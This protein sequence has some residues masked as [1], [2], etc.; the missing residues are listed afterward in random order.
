MS[1]SSRTSSIRRGPDAELP[2]WGG[3]EPAGEGF[4]DKASEQAKAARRGKG[5]P[6]APRP[7]RRRG[8]MLL[9]IGAG[10]LVLVVALVALA[11]AI[12]SRFV[13]GIVRDQAAGRITGEVRVSS[14]SLSWLGSQSLANIELIDAGKTIADVSIELDHG[15]LGL[16]AGSRQ[17]GTATLAGKIDLVRFADGT[18]NLERALAP[19]KGSASPAPSGKTEPPRVPD[20]AAVRVV[21]DSLAVSF[22]DESVAGGPLEASL[23]KIDAEA[24]IAAGD[25]VTLKFRSEATSRIGAGAVQSGTI[26]IDARVDKWQGSD[27]SLTPERINVKADLSIKDLPTALIDAL[28]GRGGT[29]AAGLGERLQLSVAAEGSMKSGQATAKLRT[30]GAGPEAALAADVSARFADDV[31][32]LSSP[33]TLA[34]TG[35]ALR[36][37]APQIDR[38]LAGQDALTLEAIPD[39]RVSVGA[40]QARVPRGGAPLDLRR[41]QLELEASAGEVAGRVRLDDTGPPRAMRLAPLSIKVSGPDLGG[42]VR[43]TASTA[44]R[45]ADETGVLASAGTIDADFTLTGLLDGA[46]VP[47]AGVPGGLNGRARV[48]G[49]ATALAQ[50]LVAA[51]GLDLRRDVGPTLDVDLTAASGGS[52]RSDLP[53]IDVTLVVTAEEINAFGA[54]TVLNDRI[55]TR[56]EGMRATLKR[57]GAIAGRFVDPSSGLAIDPTGRADLALTGVSI[58]LSPGRAPLLDQAAARGEVNIAGWTLRGSGAAG[59]PVGLASPIAIASVK[60]EALLAKGRNPEATLNVTG[61]HAGQRFTI[62]GQAQVAGLFKPTPT[63]REP[64]PLDV[65]GAAPI[66]R[67]AIRGLPTAL[68]QGV[69]ALAPAG[70]ATSGSSYRVGEA[71]DLAS[72][73]RDAVGPTLDVVASGEQ[74]GERVV[75]DARIESKGLVT[76]VKGTAD[77]KAITLEPVRAR[78]TLDPV[79]AGRLI[80]TFTDPSA[81]RPSLAGPVAAVIDLGAMVIPRAALADKAL[82]PGATIAMGFDGPVIVHGFGVGAGAERRDLGP[83]GVAGFSL[84]A[85]APLGA[86][87]GGGAGTLKA[88]VSGDAISGTRSQRVASLSADLTLPMSAGPVMAGPLLAK[89]NLAKLD[90]AVADSLLAAAVATKPTDP[91][92]VEVLGAGA[93]AS[94]VVAIDPPTG[95]MALAD[96]IASGRLRVEA[97]LASPNISTT[98]PA[99]LAMQPDRIAIIEPLGVSATLTPAVIDRLLGGSA[100]PETQLRLLAPAQATL[101][102]QKLSISRPTREQQKAGTKIGPLKAGFFDLAMSA[103]LA[104]VQL[105][106]GQQQ[107]GLTGTRVQV[108]TDP[109]KGT[110]TAALDVAEASVRTSAGAAPQ[111]AKGMGLRATIDGLADAD[112]NIATDRAVLNAQGELPVVPTALVDALAGQGGLLMDALGPTIAVSLRAESLAVG[113][114]TGTLLAEA[115]SDRANA[116]I[117]GRMTPG[118][119]IIDQA[120]IDIRVTQI[121][122]ELSRRLTHGVPVIASL[123]KTPDLQPATVAGRDLRVPTDGN[124]ANLNG[125]VEIDPGTVRFATSPLFARVLAKGNQRSEG[126]AGERL[127]PLKV[128]V[129]QGVVRLSKWE[130]PLGE[131]KILTEGT[132][133]LVSKDV[134]V[135]TWI[136]LSAL[137]EEAARAFQTTDLLGGL[138][139][140]NKEEDEKRKRQIAAPF[141]SKGKLGSVGAPTPDLKLF[142]EEVGRNFKD[143]I[144]DAPRR[145]LDGL[146]RD[147]K[148]PGGG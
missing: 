72:L 56:G 58:P 29:L 94:V 39:V 145:L 111:T 65:S 21:I 92:L 3:A 120:P 30:G 44:A 101:R 79:V 104:P 38:G 106:A 69:P 42:P 141:R 74:S 103:D 124:L 76:Q 117:Q 90:S 6:E 83:L 51:T 62:E 50:P 15:L 118:L 16:L 134:D 27:G 77:D 100:T 67:L 47:I 139:G 68:V 59:A 31:L 60:A 110:I 129:R 9:W 5:G 146:L 64:A 8:R 26:A 34:I 148:P 81:P 135:I 140:K 96:Q 17:L 11:P 78:L 36:A 132:V 49:I 35:N 125:D 52:G 91:R 119:F 109:G 20:G 136:P 66:G 7:R 28:M 98:S 107:M 147:R 93:D 108:S 1:H 102:M 128:E 40:F 88:L 23:R 10:A 32:A 71:L 70:A 12:A 142:A 33:A 113:A 13:P 126:A 37:L 97:S 82:L 115:R 45:I 131:F 25:P 122:P 138:L 53:P 86:L 95:S 19:P 105:A 24:T 85:E 61:T 63:G 48:K 75:L 22:R 80:A 137:S 55:E 4:W 87:A 41:A 54:L 123:E 114:G 116:T 144:K 2:T 89:V 121:T 43:L 18:T 84:N 127:Q 130:L 112:G 143:E 73:I 46:G 133:N 57:G 99:K 14:A